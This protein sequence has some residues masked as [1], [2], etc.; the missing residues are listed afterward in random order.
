MFEIIFLAAL[1]YLGLPWSLIDCSGF[2]AFQ[3][4]PQPRK[5]D[6]D[7]EKTWPNQ[8]KVKDNDED[9]YKYIENDKVIYRTHWKSN[10]LDN[11]EDKDN[12]NNR[13]I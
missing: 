8:Q 9:K 5:T 11:D 7:H 1:A 6:R 12:D 3:T 4:K 10:L 2:K 13:Y